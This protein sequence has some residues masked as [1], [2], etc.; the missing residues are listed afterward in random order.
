VGSCD[1]ENPSIRFSQLC[2]VGTDDVTGLK[3]HGFHEK[4]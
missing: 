2:H 4:P 3:F 1:T